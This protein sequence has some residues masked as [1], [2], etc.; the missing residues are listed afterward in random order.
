[1]KTN[2]ETFQPLPGVEQIVKE[3][4]AAAEKVLKEVTRSPEAAR[5]Y[6]IRAGILAPSSDSKSKTL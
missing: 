3:H 5:A 2:S 1:M 6:L 4:L